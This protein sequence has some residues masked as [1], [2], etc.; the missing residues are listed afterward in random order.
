[1][2]ASFC[3][4]GASR[5]AE[6]KGA[7]R[8]GHGT[9]DHG[10]TSLL[11][12]IRRTNVIEGGSGRDHPGHRRLSRADSRP[13]IV[14]LDTP[15]T[16]RFTSLR[17]RGAQVTDIVVLVVAA[18]DGVM[19]QTW[20]PST[21]EGGGRAHDRGRQQDGQTG[22][23]PEQIKQKLSTWGWFPR[24]GATRSTR[25][26]RRRRK[27]GSRNSWNLILLQADVLELKADPDRP[28]RGS[29]IESK[30]DRGRGPVA[31]VI[32]QSGTIREGD[33]FVSRTESRQGAAP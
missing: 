9:R 17:A 22:A 4:R 24:M 14:F 20:R 32:I 28:A 1:M 25:R 30:I 16:R 11:D 10:K 27:R 2:E 33:A 29:S 8:D 13:D 6:G 19:D 23:K 26:Y 31:T 5:K 12:A 18:D 7:R 15:A 3:R 21:L